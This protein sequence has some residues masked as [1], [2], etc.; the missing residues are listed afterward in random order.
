MHDWQFFFSIL[1]LC[2]YH[3]ANV[4]G[5]C[6]EETQ[7]GMKLRLIFQLCNGGRFDRER[8]ICSEFP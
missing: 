8:F 6:P 5:F 7:H 4:Q 1:E 3:L 2:S